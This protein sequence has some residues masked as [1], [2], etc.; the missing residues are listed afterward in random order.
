MFVIVTFVLKKKKV[1][2]I[3]FYPNNKEPLLFS[4]SGEAFTCKKTM[5][6]PLLARVVNLTYYEEETDG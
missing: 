4:T 3:S 5:A 1:K 2:K 6:N